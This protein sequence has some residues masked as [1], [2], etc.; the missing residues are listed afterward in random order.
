RV[1]A[2]E[3]ARRLARFYEPYHATIDAVLAAN[4]GALLLSVH[5]FTPELNGAARPFDIGVLHDDYDELAATLAAGLTAAGFAVR[6]N[7]P[8]S[9]LDGLIFSAR[10]HGRR[11]GLRYLELE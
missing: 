10:T 7:E 5:S 9:A 4:P 6:F 2:T 8:Y 3:R 1:E 11:H